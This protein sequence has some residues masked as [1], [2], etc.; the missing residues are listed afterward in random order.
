[1]KLK[2]HCCVL[3]QCRNYDE[4]Q[5]YLLSLLMP[6]K[7]IGPEEGLAAFRESAHHRAFFGVIS[8]MSSKIFRTSVWPPALAHMGLQPF[9]CLVHASSLAVWDR[10]SRS[11]PA[12]TFD[13]ALTVICV[14]IV[15]SLIFRCKESAGSPTWVSSICRRPLNLLLRSTTLGNTFPCCVWRCPCADYCGTV[16]RIWRLVAT[17]LGRRWRRRSAWVRVLR[18]D[19]WLRCQC[20][21]C[22]HT[23]YWNGSWDAVPVP[24]CHAL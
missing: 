10:L 12:D 20:S 24:V 16:W 13:L 3:N 1:V 8:L 11:G 21:A 9:L 7:E 15:W 14:I 19:K 5:R 23:V 22:S 4:D 6:C 18:W 17:L 2:Y